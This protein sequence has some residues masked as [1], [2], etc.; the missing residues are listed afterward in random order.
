MEFQTT[1]KN[2]NPKISVDPE[3]F[4]IFQHKVERTPLFTRV[5]EVRHK[6][7]HGCVNHFY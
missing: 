2:Y 5:T 1:I 6:H 7:G 3:I 4:A